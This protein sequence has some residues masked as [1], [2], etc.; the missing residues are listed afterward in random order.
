MTLSVSVIDEAL[1]AEKIA[2]QHALERSP[3]HLALLLSD[4][5]IIRDYHY[6]IADSIAKTADQPSGRLNIT[7]PPRAG[8]SWLGI[9]WAAVWIA[10]RHPT[11]EIV[12][13][14]ASDSLSREHGGKIKDI[15]DRHGPA[16]GVKVR[17]G[18]NRKSDLKWESGGSLRMV[19]IGSQLT[20]HGAHWM[21]IDD[22]YRDWQDAHSPAIVARSTSWFRSVVM[23]RLYPYARVIHTTTIW[24]SRDFVAITPSWPL[25]RIPAICD[26]AD[27]P[28]GRAIGQP[29]LSPTIR[30][31][32]DHE[33]IKRWDEKRD[34]VG[35]D[36]WQTLYQGK[37]SSSHGSL[38]DAA[39]LA[40]QQWPADDAPRSPA[41]VLVDPSTKETGSPDSCGIVLATLDIE[42]PDVRRMW[43]TADH[44]GHYTLSEWVQK[45]VEL[46]DAHDASVMVEGNQGGDSWAALIASAARDMDIPVPDVETVY[47]KRRKIDRAGPVG[48][49]GHMRYDRIRI[50]LGIYQ[51]IDELENFDPARESPGSLDAVSMGAKKYLGTAARYTS[52]PESIPTVPTDDY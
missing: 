48:V 16:L 17:H 11:D 21:L 35:E 6:A 31:D 7:A 13:A 24:S 3:A 44:T 20:G 39:T 37:P 4:E 8:K 51:L 5:T 36:V 33:A 32:S 43:I 28:L 18:H 49:V 27:D 23:T 2:V 34:D 22:A 40:R 52:E 10:A 29:L 41:V 9:V 30:H 38:I 45:V 1:T 19:G 42:G 47:V 26:S 50:R 25:L 14:C 46:A 15:I 12:I